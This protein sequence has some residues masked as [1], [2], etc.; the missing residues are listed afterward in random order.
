MSANPTFVF[1]YL[2]S[3]P[4]PASKNNTPSASLYDRTTTFLSSASKAI[5]NPK[6]TTE[7]LRIATLRQVKA[8]MEENVAIKK[9]AGM[10]VGEVDKQGLRA[11]EKALE[12]L[13]AEEEK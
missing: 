2:P 4:K 7:Q 6:L 9:K 10:S 11:V 12:G 13:A 8:D 1:S 5:I 3:A